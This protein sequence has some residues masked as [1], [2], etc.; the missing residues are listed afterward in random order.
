MEKD[1]FWRST[2]FANGVDFDLV[3]VTILM[4]ISMHFGYIFFFCGSER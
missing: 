4:M 1:V 2:L 3:Q